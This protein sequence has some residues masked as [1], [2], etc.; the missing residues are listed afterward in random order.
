MPTIFVRSRRS[1]M[2]LMGIGLLDRAFTAQRLEDKNKMQNELRV[3]LRLHRQA[4]QLEFEYSLES[5]P[6][7]ILIF[8]R[9]WD[10][11]ANALKADWAYLQIQDSTAIVQR[12]MQQLPQGLHID[13]PIVPYGRELVAH[14][15][16]NGKFVLSLPLKEAGAY[17]G[18]LHHTASRKPSQIHTVKFELGWCPKPDSLPPA[19]HPVEMN[20]EKLWLLP[21]SLVSN[22]QRLASSSP[23]QLEVPGLAFE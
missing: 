7:T 11:Q 3:E 2:T 1:M 6:Q 18:F 5:A 23:V 16:A 10:V 9:L 22:M 19:I 8:D 14:S 13:T 12:L 15:R 17:S 4:E 20:G 21:Y